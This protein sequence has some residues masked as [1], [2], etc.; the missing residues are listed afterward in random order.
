MPLDN[1]G[2][3]FSK[4][5]YDRYTSI[6]RKR[7]VKRSPRWLYPTPS[8]LQYK[9]YLQQIINSAYEHTVKQIVPK[10][11]GIVVEAGLY[12][13]DSW[14]SNVDK[15]LDNLKIEVNTNI[16]NQK[17]MLI[18]I[19][20]K[21]SDWNNKEWQK[22]MKA[23]VGVELYQKELNIQPMMEG[24]VN[25]NIKLI[26]DIS[27]NIE[28]NIGTTI[29]Q[30]VL[31]GKSHKEIANNLIGTGIDKG[32][33]TS[34]ENRVK[35]IAR[36]QVAKFNG[37]LMR[38]RQTGVGIT[39]YT[40][41]TSGDERVRETHRKADGNVYDWSKP[42]AVTGGNHPGEDYQCRCWADPDFSDIL[43]ESEEIEQVVEPIPSMVFEQ[44]NIKGLLE[45]ATTREE[46][47]GIIRNHPSFPNVNIESFNR[48]SGM[49][50]LQLG[51]FKMRAGNL[52]SAAINRA[53]KS[54]VKPVSKISVKKPVLKPVNKPTIPPKY[55]KYVPEKVNVEFDE[56]GFL[57]TDPV[58]GAK[59][60]LDV[61]KP[62]LLIENKWYDSMGDYWADKK[63]ALEAG[64]IYPSE[65][66]TIKDLEKVVK[67]KTYEDL[68][69]QFE[70]MDYECHIGYTPKMVKNNVSTLFHPNQTTAPNNP[71]NCINIHNHPGSHNSTFSSSDLSN[72]AENIIRRYGSEFS[73]F[74][75]H[76]MGKKFIFKIQFKLD[77][78]RKLNEKERT[79]VF[80]VL[81]DKEGIKKREDIR[82]KAMMKESNKGLSSHG[83]LWDPNKIWSEAI[84]LQMEEEINK[85]KD[86]AKYIRID[87]ISKKRI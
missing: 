81:R 63:V 82:Y 4:K 40:W 12:K 28:K 23:V 50:D 26:S 77:K 27:S 57:K 39:R 61:P 53:G 3:L 25:N 47:L 17:S 21:T 44:Q 75:E 34:V 67:T 84:H 49:N 14:P 2:K 59:L 13:A 87:A 85:I 9:R 37:N 42:P 76:V 79:K 58:K 74:E 46:I 66:R 43:G 68:W 1:M 6:G 55:V 15:L 78:I 31:S 83:S 22:I 33:F 70:Q 16:V 54:I 32:V 52:L 11:E 48:L 86:V 19:G 73:T 71:N 56:H 36:D 65:I 64:K 8:E 24:F 41:R 29:Q 60:P 72:M 20:Q 30:G 80:S 38:T 5:I 51:L 69:K 7:R 45:G 18:D 62:R 35:L 10:L